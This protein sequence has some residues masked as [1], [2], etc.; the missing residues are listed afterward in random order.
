M[1]RQVFRAMYCGL[2]ALLLVSNSIAQSERERAVAGAGDKYVI[3]A[4]AGGV[5]YVEGTVAVVRKTGTSGYLMRRDE[6][7][8]GDRVS[9]GADGKAEILLNPGSY[10]RVGPNTAF[11]FIST[12][13]DDVRIRVDSGSAIFEVYAADEFS[14]AVITPKTMFDLIESGVYRIDVLPQG[15]AR[16]EVWEGKAQTGSSSVI[17]KKGRAAVVANGN[18]SVAKFDRG[19]KDAFEIWSKD[20]AK[21]LAK[22]VA[23]LRNRDMRSALMSSFMGNRWGMFNSF[24]VWVY[25]PMFG[26]YCFLPFGRGWGSP[27]GYGFGHSIWYYNFPPVIYMPPVTGNPGPVNTPIV[28]AG[29]RGPIPPFIRMQ[30]TGSGATGGST[31]G[32]GLGDSSDVKWDRGGSGNSGGSPP[33]FSAPPPAPTKSDPPVKGKDN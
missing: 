7:Q 30:Q 8:I 1:S 24:G 27:Y 11:E 19:A 23:T 28:S 10:L 17:V 9:T 5:N 25:D 26:G 22:N 14:V 3:S 21:Q 20:R 31:W 18:A 16:I 2:F 12:S 29:T 33:I 15:Q 4:K 13:L 6:I 32:G